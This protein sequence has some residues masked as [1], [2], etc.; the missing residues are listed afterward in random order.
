MDKRRNWDA[1]FGII[2]KYTGMKISPLQKILVTG[3]L[4]TKPEMYNEIK[5][6]VNAN[7]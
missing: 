1:L 5:E 3:L 2:S 7:E 6:W 4:E